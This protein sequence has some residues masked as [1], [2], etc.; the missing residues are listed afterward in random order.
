MLEPLDFVVIAVYFVGVAWL[1]LRV[2][3]KQQTTTDYFLGG[4]D[5]PWWAICFSIIATETSTLTVIGI[6]AVAYGGSLVFLQLTAGYLVGRLLVSAV[7]LPRYFRGELV[8]AYAFLGE[9]FGDGMRGLASVTFML[10]RLLADGVRLF[11]TAIPLRII[12]SGAG[13]ELS[14]PIIIA[15][16]GAV[17]V[18]YTFVGGLRAVVWV[19]AV[20]MVL[21]LGGAVLAVVLLLNALP[22]GWW[23]EAVAAGKT[24][25]L[26]VG[27]GPVAW[28]TSPYTL[29][30]AVLGGAVFSMA[31]HGAD[32]LIVQRVLACRSLR[33]GQKAMIGSGIGVVV[34]FTLFLFVGLGL[35]A[36]YRGAPPDALGLTRGDEVFPK[37]IVEGMPAGVSGL[38]LA[39]IV[40]A[41]MSTLSSSLNAL[42]GA[43]VLDVVERLGGRRMEEGAALRL[44]RVLTLVW[45]VAFVGFAML[46]RSLEN[47]VVEL[48]LGIAGFTYGGL[49]GAFLLGIVSRRARQADAVAAF[50]VTVIA[51]SALIFGLY[52]S[53]ESAG[54][55]FRLR[56]DADARAALGLVP[57]A[58]PLYTVFGAAGMV[59][60]GSFLAWVRGGRR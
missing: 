57:L 7:L 58:W 46:F 31:S 59:G 34:Q 4:R 44:S 42:A 35:W 23:A 21:Y 54:W 19:D 28:L 12:A 15:V 24:Q 49:L 36:Y 11:A 1:G 22:T 52:Y 50:V 45:G 29:P 38:L 60:I 2:G 6:P 10:T 33:D 3:G 51:M 56:P 48:G 5:L 20:Q 17:T 25:V 40:A 43:T 55:V 41:A 27:S 26:D 30:T 47:P 13:V 9:R 18:A 53:T 32:Q 39:G 16:L 14:Y 8:T 37:F